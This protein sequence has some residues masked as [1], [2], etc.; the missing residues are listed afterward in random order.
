MIGT[1][2]VFRNKLDKEWNVLR[3]K[4]ILVANGYNQQE[5]IDFD[6]TYVH[7]AR[8]DSSFPNTSNQWVIVWWYP[9]IMELKLVL[10]FTFKKLKKKCFWIGLIDMN[11][12]TKVCQIINLKMLRIRLTWVF[13][14]TSYLTLLIKLLFYV[15]TQSQNCLIL[16]S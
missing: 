15:I 13:H 6:K 10:N 5:G 14:C 7:V 11:Y 1:W 9:L 3:N 2:R 16:I 4:V 8:L 12:K